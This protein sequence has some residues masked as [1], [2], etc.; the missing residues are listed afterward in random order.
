[1]INACCFACS[2]RQFIFLPSN[3]RVRSTSNV[4]RSKIS[5]RCKISIQ[6][7]TSFDQKPSFGR[8]PHSNKNIRSKTFDPVQNKIVEE[9]RLEPATTWNSNFLSASLQRRFEPTTFSYN[10]QL[11]LHRSFIA[12][13]FVQFWLKNKN[14]YFLTRI[15]SVQCDICKFVPK[16]AI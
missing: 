5:I 4:V 9:M 8:K 11:A 14:L 13:T 2:C 16:K 3:T 6:P 1:M 10:L 7:Q 12:S 15:D